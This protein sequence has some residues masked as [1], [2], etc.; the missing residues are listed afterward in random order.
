[1]KTSGVRIVDE[2]MKFNATGNVIPAQWY[3]TITKGKT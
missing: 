2:M 3:K 1:M